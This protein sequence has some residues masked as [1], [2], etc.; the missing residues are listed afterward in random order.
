MK[1]R[2]GSRPSSTKEDL[3]R[4]RVKQEEEEFRTGYRVPDLTDP[5]NIA[6]LIRWDGSISSL[7]TIKF[8]RVMK[9]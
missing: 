4:L 8:V 3:L 1:A 7:G 6:N 2:R 9:E 5:E